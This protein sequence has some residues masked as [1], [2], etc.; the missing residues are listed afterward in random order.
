VRFK[1]YSLTRP[2]T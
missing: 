1:A 2:Q